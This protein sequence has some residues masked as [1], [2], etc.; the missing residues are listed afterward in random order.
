MSTSAATPVHSVVI[1]GAG[2]AGLQAARLL[3]PACP[4]L[5]VLEA[6]DTIGGRVKQA[7]P[8]CCVE[9][10]AP[11]PVETGP[12]FVHGARS[13]LKAVLDEMG[14]KMREYAWPD[15]WYFGKE[16]RLADSRY[17]DYE[18]QRVHKL[19]EEVGARKL[20]ATDISAEQ[21]LRRQGASDRMVA[22]A[23]ACYANDFGCSI[24]QLG[25]REL[26]LENR[27]WESGDTYLVLDRSL[28]DVAAHLA[29]SVQSNIRLRWPVTFIRRD[30]GGVTLQG[31]PGRQVR[32]RH[33]VVTCPLAVLQ[34][35]D[36]AFRP[37]LPAPKLAAL[38]RVKMSNAIKVI[39]VFSKPFWPPDFFD[40]V[41]TDCFIPEF[42]VTTY[43]TAGGESLLCMT[44]F[45]AGTRAE[46]MSKMRQGTVILKT[47][48][49][50]DQMF[51][52]FTDRHP[53]T[54]AY[55][56]GH[57]ADWSRE[58]WT[59]GAYTYPT[60]GAQEGDRQT[61][62]EPVDDRLF[63]AGE[64]THAGINPC[65]QAA[66]ETGERAAKQVV[67]ALQQGRAAKL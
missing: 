63:F 14:C 50:L 40:V 38:D 12:E 54:S 42:W 17:E 65:L 8:L 5:L 33:V 43:P 29:A 45:A 32:C 2:F 60:L 61:L 41:C 18:L 58:R 21:W 13:C 28:R 53:A 20:P 52:S 9:G 10:V 55:V 31:P 66:M 36:V 6:A 44:G 51:G 16:R 47:L 67:K 1:V 49:Q 19:F 34:R 22:I 4:D 35:G 48:A 27:N 56:Q 30:A 24:E 59:Q 64:A 39:L 11:W 57:V 7:W 46:E 62:A 3:K 23:D 26:V 37:P 15:H 25:L